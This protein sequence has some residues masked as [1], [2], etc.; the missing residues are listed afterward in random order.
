MVHQEAIH[1]RLAVA[2]HEHRL[3]KDHH[4]VQCRCGR[5]TDL[6]SIKHLDHL[7]V[8]RDVV[9]EISEAQLTLTQLPIQQIAPVAFIH[10]DQVIG[11]HRGLV[12]LAAKQQALHHRLHGGDVHPCIAFH[13]ALAQFL[14]AVDR[15]EALQAFHPRFLEGIGGLGAEFRAVHQKQHAPES[16]GF[17]QPIDQGHAGFGFARAGGHGQH[18]LP[19]ACGN[20]RFGGLD[21][22]ALVGA[23]GKAK[24]E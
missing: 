16:P 7:P 5:E 11:V 6:D 14:D 3:A 19:L 1:H 24:A 4:R 9:V 13:L 23:Q 22:A 2:V 17:E 15:S 18:D 10:H 8:L 21:R 20:R 12:F